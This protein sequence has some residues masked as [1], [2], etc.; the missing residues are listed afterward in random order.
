MSFHYI[1]KTYISGRTEI[2][3]DFSSKESALEAYHEQYKPELKDSK[4]YNYSVK[5]AEELSEDLI[6][7]YLENPQ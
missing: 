4:G 1:I 2:V 5:P 7:T 6:D 3:D